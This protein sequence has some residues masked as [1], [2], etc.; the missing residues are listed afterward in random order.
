MQHSDSD[1]WISW[2]PTKIRQIF[3]A[4]I[5]R[6]AWDGLGDRKDNC[7]VSD[8]QKNGDTELALQT[9]LNEY[10]KIMSRIDNPTNLEEFTKEL[11]G[12]YHDNGHNAMAD[13]MYWRV[14]NT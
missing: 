5:F 3:D 10:P 2:Q 9:V 14:F 7:I 12:A 8:N 1:Q 13:G 6:W 11:G 4:V